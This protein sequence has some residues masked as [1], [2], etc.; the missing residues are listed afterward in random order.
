MKLSYQLILVAIISALTWAVSGCGSCNCSGSDKKDGR[1]IIHQ[2]I[3]WEGFKENAKIKDPDNEACVAMWQKC[4]SICME[5]LT[6]P[7]KQRASKCYRTCYARSLLSGDCT[8]YKDRQERED[9]REN[10][11]YQELDPRYFEEKKRQQFRQRR[12]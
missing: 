4:Y 3:K 1:T 11:P 12:R 7:M 8:R 2:P 6:E 9:V 10:S 5:K